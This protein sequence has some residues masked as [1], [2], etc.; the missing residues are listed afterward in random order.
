MGD[1]FDINKALKVDTKLYMIGY[2]YGE[3]IAKTTNGLKVQFTQGTVSQ[4]SD[5]YKVLYSIPSLPGSSGS[6]VI[7][8]WGNLVAINY[9]GY[10]NSQSFNYGILAKHLKNM[11]VTDVNEN[12]SSHM[13]TKPALTKNSD[14][15]SNINQIRTFVDLE[16]Q[17]NFEAIY[18]CFAS[19]MRR[20]WDL[21]NPTKAQLKNRYEHSWSITTDGKNE[22]VDIKKVDAFTYDLHAIYKF[23]NKKGEAKELKTVIRLQFDGYGKIVETYGK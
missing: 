14:D 7:D 12:K 2:N 6:P 11:L 18:K 3:Q 17:R 19:N 9:A 15:E 23:T 4:E 20:Y 16:S 21:T 10:T 8:Q 22:I 13:V 1:T 5:D